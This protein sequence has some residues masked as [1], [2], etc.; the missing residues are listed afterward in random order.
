MCRYVGNLRARRCSG[1]CQHVD[2]AVRTLC[3]AKR[4]INDVGSVLVKGTM[5]GENHDERQ[6]GITKYCQV[7][8]A[9]S[10]SQHFPKIPDRQARTPH[11]EEQR[12]R[13]FFPGSNTGSG[14]AIASGVAGCT[15]ADRYTA[16]SVRSSAWDGNPADKIL[17]H[18]FTPIRLV[19]GDT[20]HAPEKV[21]A[22]GSNVLTRLLWRDNFYCAHV[23]RRLFL[24]ASCSDHDQQRRDDGCSLDTLFRARI[25]AGYQP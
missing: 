3:L 22:R 11:K 5:K 7:C 25:W 24:S 18:T 10:S 20:A 4:K 13:S 16:A 17:F 2:L 21:E 14:Q 6:P 9:L 19:P 1:C 8:P 12:A 23:K 15:G